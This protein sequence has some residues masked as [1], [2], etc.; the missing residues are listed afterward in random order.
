[1]W[2]PHKI[3][4]W[5]DYIKGLYWHEKALFF[6]AT[7]I[8]LKKTRENPFSP[9]N[10]EVATTEIND[11]YRKFCY[12]HGEE[13]LY[14]QRVSYILKKLCEK[15]ILLKTDVVSLGRKGRT[16][17]Y[18]YALNPETIY[19]AFQKIEGWN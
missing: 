6:S 11:A 8:A 10:I 16:T 14:Y 3:K 5:T 15:D 17:K 13:P 19:K 12:R 4:Y 1:M 9:D 7:K 2:E 18:I